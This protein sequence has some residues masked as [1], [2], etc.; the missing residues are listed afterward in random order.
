MTKTTDKDTDK[1]TTAKKTTAKK[2]ARTKTV[3]NKSTKSSSTA[4]TSAAPKST[5]RS[6]GKATTVD[7]SDKPKKRAAAP[8]KK[9]PQDAVGGEAKPTPR[10]RKAPVRSKQVEVTVA[11]DPQAIA[12]AAYHLY[13]L[14]G[15]D[16]GQDVDDWLEA[17]RRL[18]GT[19]A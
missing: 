14:R 17:E 18:T 8:R 15:G 7:G 9:P 13:L 10:S 11:A 1:K 2:P 4:K 5:K 3:A 12:E 16:H 6:Q 19:H